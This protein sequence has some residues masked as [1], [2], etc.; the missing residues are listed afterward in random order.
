MFSN[1]NSY[2]KTSKRKQEFGLTLR[3][4]NFSNSPCNFT[5]VNG[6]QLSALLFGSWV[7][8]ALHVYANVQGGKMSTRWQF[9]PQQKDD[10]RASSACPSLHSFP[11][12]AAC[13]PRQIINVTVRS[14]GSMSFTR[15]HRNTLEYK[16]KL[17]L[18][19]VR[20]Q[21]KSFIKAYL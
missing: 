4:I 20:I 10:R 8:L 11:L 12:S 17:L 3:P 6:S 21:T 13:A 16:Q 2:E 15:G 18:E 7:S 9:S 14:L 19:L 1:L 5:P